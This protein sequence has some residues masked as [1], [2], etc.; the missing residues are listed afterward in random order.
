[1]EW[2]R[3][4]VLVTGGGG[5]LG[6]ALVRRLRELRCGEIRSL[7]RTAQPGLAALG[8]KAMCGDLRDAATAAAACRGC[9]VVFHVAAKA[10]VWGA[11]KD[12]HAVNVLGTGNMLSAARAAGVAAFVHTSSPSAAYD[13]CHDAPGM[14][15]TAPPPRRFLAAYPASKAKAEAEVLA[16]STPGMP[17]AALRPH[18]IWGPGDHHLLPRLLERARR[19]R[20]IQ[21]GNGKNRVDMTYVDNAAAAHLLAA[22]NLRGSQTAAGRAY[23]ISDGEPVVLWEWVAALLRELGIPPIRRRISFRTAYL[24]GATLEMGARLLPGCPEPP[25][26]R[27][28]AG[29]LAHDHWFDL[30]AA[31]R[32]L[33][34]APVVAPDVAMARTLAW[35]R[36]QA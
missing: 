36:E 19:G 27:F 20:L 12:F 6:G 11:E 23:F 16:A 14:D 13:P 34:Y 17:T 8:V 30:A 18:L 3:E 5:F 35:L 7:G 29:Q 22:E 24:L 1:M 15:E 9:T 32:D 21:V 25:M 26:T 33:G 10:G 28:I 31:R 4:T 2:R